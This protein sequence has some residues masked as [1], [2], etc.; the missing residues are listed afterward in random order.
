MIKRIK[1][2][3]K[4]FLELELTR[5]NEYPDFYK[6]MKATKDYTIEEK[7]DKVLPKEIVYVNKD[8]HKEECAYGFKVNITNKPKTHSGRRDPH[9]EAM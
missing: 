1:K 4:N 8:F 9:S 5:Q 2:R 3:N 6:V 7:V